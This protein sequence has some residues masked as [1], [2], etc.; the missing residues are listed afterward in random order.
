MPSATERSGAS[1]WRR[2]VSVKR[3][4]R[5]SSSQVQ[6]NHAHVGLGR[7]DPPLQAEQKLVRIEGAAA[8]IDADREAALAVGRRP[9]ET[10]EKRGRQVVDRLIA[11]IFERLERRGAPRARHAGHQN[12]AVARA[13]AIPHVRTPFRHG[14]PI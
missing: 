10:A 4:V 5:I 3:R 1:G 6:E 9:K 2:L 7:A 11:E 14:G 12:D 13:E 8:R